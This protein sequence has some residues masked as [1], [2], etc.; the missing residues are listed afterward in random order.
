M[1]FNFLSIG[2]V[3]IV[4]MARMKDKMKVDWEEYESWKW[5]FSNRIKIR[6]T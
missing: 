3:R 4:L 5:N 6:G 2:Y 1:Y